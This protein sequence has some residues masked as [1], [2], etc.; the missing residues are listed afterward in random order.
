MGDVAQK[1]LEGDVAQRR[2]IGIPPRSVVEHPG[3]RRA[4]PSVGEQ[5]RSIPTGC[6]PA[7]HDEDKRRD[8]A[9]PPPHLSES[10]KLANRGRPIRVAECALRLR[11][12]LP[13]GAVLPGLEFHCSALADRDAGGGAR[14]LGFGLRDGGARG[15]AILHGGHDVAPGGHAGNVGC[16]REEVPQSLAHVRCYGRGSHFDLLGVVHHVVREVLA[17]PHGAARVG[18]PFLRRLQDT[19]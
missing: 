3:M 15:R 5:L 17:H 16:D 6:S 14:V 8:R 19:L 18:Y 7:C 12:A 4:P 9:R 11:A 13:A 2:A 10:Q 1:V